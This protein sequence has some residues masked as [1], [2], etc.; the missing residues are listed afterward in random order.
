MKKMLTSV[1]NLLTPGG[2]AYNR[3]I[4][5]YVYSVI[6]RALDTQEQMHRFQ[7]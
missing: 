4:K 1:G 7:L 3:G 5:T 6:D 2:K